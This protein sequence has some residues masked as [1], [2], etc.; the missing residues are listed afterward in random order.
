MNNTGT[1]YKSS[2]ERYRTFAIARHWAGAGRLRWWCCV[3]GILSFILTLANHA[4]FS[5]SWVTAALSERVFGALGDFLQ[6]EEWRILKSNVF[7]WNSVWNWENPLRRLFR[8]CN[9]LMGR[10]VWAV[11]NVTSGISVSNRAGGPSKMIPNLDGLLRQRATITLYSFP[12]FNACNFLNQIYILTANLKFLLSQY[13]K[14]K[15]HV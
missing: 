8:C 5:E 14:Y 13:K 12:V 10:T 11:R 4:T 15:L 2:P 9:R 3:A 7:A 1:K 6:V